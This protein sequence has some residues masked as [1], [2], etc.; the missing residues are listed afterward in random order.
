MKTLAERLNS[1]VGD[2]TRNE[3]LAQMLDA[4]AAGELLDWGTEVSKL[5]VNATDGLDDEAANAAMEPRLKA[6][7]HAMRSLG[8]WA[9]GKYV[10]AASRI[11]LRDKLLEQFKIILG[12]GAHLPS[13]EHF[14]EFLSQVDDKS[15]TPRQLIL[16]MRQ[17]LA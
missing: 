16:K 12:E 7:R 8:N 6:I 1:V 4:D 10:D 11:Q 13:V 17:L 15:L 5:V 14:G 2:L 3:S 9:A